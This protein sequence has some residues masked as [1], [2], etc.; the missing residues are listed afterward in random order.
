MK[1]YSYIITRDF[2]FA[3]NPYFGYCTL[4]TC[5]PRIR[6]YAEIG[7]WI[8]GFGSVQTPYSHKLVYMMRV[9]ST[10][11]F[12]EYWNSPTFQIKK[13]VFN[14]SG[15]Y[16]YGDNIYHYDKGVW[17]QKYSHHSHPDGSVNMRNLN[18]DTETDRVLISSTFYYFGHNAIDVPQMF[19]DIIH[20]GRGHSIIENK[21]HINDFIDYVT[22]ETSKGIN[23][24]PFSRI[25]G[26]MIYYKG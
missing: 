16:A 2:G 12:D 8:A 5:K 10:M 4:A 21:N 14:R 22:R 25:P 19:H 11:T 20:R 26:E 9:D 7:D 17:M 1:L 3:P 6:R 23:G 24:T 13:P 15:N 18:R